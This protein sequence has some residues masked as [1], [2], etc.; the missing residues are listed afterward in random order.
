[1]LGSLDLKSKK[2]LHYNNYKESKLDDRRINKYVKIYGLCL[3][4][5]FAVSE[6]KTG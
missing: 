3:F 2:P 5:Y 6:A 4:L 1:M